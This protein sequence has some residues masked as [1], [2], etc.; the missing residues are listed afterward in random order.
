MNEAIITF[1]PILAMTVFITVLVLIAFNSIYDLIFSFYQTR[2]KRD[3]PL[4][5]P[6]ITV[7]I[8][9]TDDIQSVRDCLLSL[10]ASE[11]KKYDVVVANNYLRYGKVDNLSKLLAAHPKPGYY[12]KSRKRHG[13]ERLIKEGYRRSKKGSAVMLV[14]SRVR[15]A[16]STL[17]R[18]ANRQRALAH[19]DILHIDTNTY[20]Y[21][22]VGVVSSLIDAFVRLL[23]LSSSRLWIR[24]TKQLR[25]RMVVPSLY[26]THPEHALRHNYEPSIV[27]YGE[28]Y[29]ESEATSLLNRVWLMTRVLTFLLLVWVCISIVMAALGGSRP[30]SF[31]ATWVAVALTGASLVLFDTRATTRQKIEAT[32]CLSFMPILILLAFAASVID[33]RLLKKRSLTISP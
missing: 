33:K 22:F 18:V 8:M 11:Y 5:T 21:G 10:R 17:Q 19:G 20:R 28:K 16:G 6:H 32:L 30:E 25:P 3:L 24:K 12:Y 4:A 7:I 31:I 14:D 2:S 27:M 13:Y 26:I 23:R 29:R 15:F 9:A 1:A